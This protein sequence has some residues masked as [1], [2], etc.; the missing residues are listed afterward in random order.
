MCYAWAEWCNDC[1]H[2]LSSLKS[3][4]F[5]ILIGQKL[6]HLLQLFISFWQEEGYSVICGIEM[7]FGKFWLWVLVVKKSVLGH[8][9]IA[10]RKNLPFSLSFYH[11]VLGIIF[12]KW[13]QLSSI[14]FHSSCS[15]TRSCFYNLWWH[16]VYIKCIN[17]V[18]DYVVLTV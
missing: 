12:W 9:K 10:V 17:G 13:G 2:W 11:I 7:A 3:F 16:G 5:L 8:D 18:K 14:L 15:W 6:G 1:S 4:S